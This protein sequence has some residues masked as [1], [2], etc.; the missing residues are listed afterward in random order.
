MPIYEFYCQGCHTVFNFYSSRVNTETRPSCPRCG[1]PELPRK[2]SRFATLKHPGDDE[3][4]PFDTV[5][6]SRLEGAMESLI[7]EMGEVEN[8]EDP[9]AMGRLMRRFSDLSGLEPGE[10]MEEFVERLE[11]GE[12]PE[13][14][15]QEMESSDD[16]GSIDELFQLR[17][18][19]HDRRSRRPRVDDELYFL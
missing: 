5:D 7:A 13:S 6:D 14:L 8:E 15:E 10:R 19:V 17:K 9:R 4:D 3:P 18:A 1:R 12:D 11:A 2:P 16:D